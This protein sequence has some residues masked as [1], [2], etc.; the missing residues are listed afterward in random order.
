MRYGYFMT[1]LVSTYYFFKFK[2]ARFKS[3][4]CWIWAPGCS[5]SMSDGGSYSLMIHAIKNSALGFC[6]ISL[7]SIG[8][9]GLQ[10]IA[11][12]TPPRQW[13][14][15]LHTLCWTAGR[16]ALCHPS[17]HRRTSV[18]GCGN[19]C[20]VLAAAKLL[21]ITNTYVQSSCPERKNLQQPQ[22]QPTPLKPILSP[23]LLLLF[24]FMFLFV[25]TTRH[26]SQAE[27]WLDGPVINR[28]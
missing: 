21:L 13:L 11:F 26:D 19:D 27:K 15:Y 22:N 8:S 14:Y 7:W 5:L 28:N 2:W 20:N 9:K 10:K 4:T 23:A 12:L 3:L 25:E 16:L 6:Q 24:L 18:F 1:N 17:Q